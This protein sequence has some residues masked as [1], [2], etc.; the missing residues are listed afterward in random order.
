MVNYYTRTGD[1][2]PGHLAESED[3]N[4][5][6]DSIAVA[7]RQLIVDGFGKAF[8]LDGSEFAFEL[9][10]ATRVIDQE[11]LNGSSWKSLQ[12]LYIEQTIDIEK[13]SIL[14]LKVH[15][16]N[17]TQT[18]IN[19]VFRLKNLITEYSPGNPYLATYTLTVSPGSSVYS[20]PFNLD[21][22]PVM[23]TTLLIERTNTEGIYIL[24]DEEGN[25]NESMAESDNEH[26]YENI[27]GDLYFQTIYGNQR[28]YDIQQA[29]T[30]INGEKV[31]PN[32]THITLSPGLRFGNRYDV[33]CFSDDQSFAVVEGYPALL[34]E[35]PYDT[36]PYDI[37][38]IAT[39]YVPK[40]S[41]STA[42]FEV[43]QTD[44]LGQHRIRS[45]HER[46]RRMEKM[47]Y[48][49]KSNDP[50]RRV[51]YT[52]DATE[53]FD[54]E[55]SSENLILPDGSI[56]GQDNLPTTVSRYPVIVN[57]SRLKFPSSYNTVIRYVSI[58]SAK[59]EFTSVK[60]VPYYPG[61][62][63]TGLI[64]P[65]PTNQSIISERQYGIHFNETPAFNTTESADDITRAKKYTKHPLLSKSWPI[66][67]GLPNDMTSKDVDYINQCLTQLN[68]GFRISGGTT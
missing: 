9:T 44:D 14:I 11:N 50:P 51:K 58:G 49:M 53:F 17:E 31:A 27:G 40:N 12:Q 59:E 45:H 39:I 55:E 47:A 22:I 68:A 56:Y 25:Y 32:D 1:I 21:H 6:Q 38:R 34:P 52:L 46:I 24:Y 48:W 43:D 5:I 26:D 42:E 29:M 61:P 30:I 19:V 64:Y 13:S 15:L 65:V 33:V 20:I 3:I 23:P 41:T 62:G 8:V 18:N 35:P 7:L 28:T 57:T 66:I 54:E 4:H 37:L 67:N 60:Y 63:Y 16:K 2:Y 10:P 36:I